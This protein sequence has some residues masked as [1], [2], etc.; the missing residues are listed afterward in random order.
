MSKNNESKPQGSTQGT[1]TS[2]YK[3]EVRSNNGSRVVTTTSVT[4]PPKGK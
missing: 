3:G 1:R 4:K 2:I